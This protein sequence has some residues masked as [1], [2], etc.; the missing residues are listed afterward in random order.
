MTWTKRPGHSWRS[1]FGKVAF[2]RI[3]PVVA[4]TMLSMNASVP[5]AGRTRHRLSG[6]AAGSRLRAA[7]RRAGGLLALGLPDGV[8]TVTVSG[9]GPGTGGCR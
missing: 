7:W 8:A 1:A 4:S 5:R 2:S 6:L 3:V 9:R